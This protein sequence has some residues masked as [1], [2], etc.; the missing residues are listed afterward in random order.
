MIQLRQ[1]EVRRDRTLICRVPDLDV[2]AGERLGIVGPNGCGKS[3]LLMVLAGLDGSA[4]GGCEVAVPARDRV[5]VHQQPFL[6]TGTVLAN[7]TYG[8]RAHGVAAQSAART[9]GQWLERLGVDGLAHRDGASLSGGEK[10]RVAL[11]RAMALRPRLL[12]LDEPLA[13]LDASGAERVAAALDALP[14]TTIL[15]AAPAELA[16]N[17]VARTYVMTPSAG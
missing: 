17:L 13:E 12:L 7:A 4:R 5:Y 1:L 16:G 9:A 15:I 2:R 14:E 10:R 8:L 11:A 3:T 6:F